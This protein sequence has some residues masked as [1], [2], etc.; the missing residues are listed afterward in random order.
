MAIAIVI[1]VIGDKWY[2]VVPP[3]GTFVPWDICVIVGKAIGRWFSA[4]PEE[5]AS[6]RHFCALADDARGPEMADEAMD[7]LKMSTVLLCCPFFWMAF[8]MNYTTWQSFGNCMQPL[9]LFNAEMASA[10]MNPILVVALVPLFTNLIYPGIN[11]MGYKFGL[12]TRIWVGMLVA[13]IAFFVAAGMQMSIESDCVFAVVDGEPV[14]Q[15]EWMSIM[16]QWIPYLIITTGEILF[17]ISGLNFTYEQ[18]GKRMKA[19]AAALWLL[20]SAF[21]NL[22]DA[23]LLGITNPTTIPPR[24]PQYPGGMVM[25]NFFWLVGGLCFIFGLMEAVVVRF[26]VYREDQPYHAA[27]R[28]AII[29]ETLAREAEIKEFGR[30][31]LAKGTIGR[32]AIGN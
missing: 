24:L 7:V 22:L 5:K 19:S 27:D 26:Y 18:V 10:V 25:S 9:G 14:C 2:R 11:K 4:T 13:G 8:D 3:T 1:F 16:F 28:E 32:G 15:S 21:G 17:S 29:S 6:A 31:S 12:A 23:V 30:D 20:T